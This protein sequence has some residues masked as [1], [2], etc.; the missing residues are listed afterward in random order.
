MQK[1]I[2]RIALA[3]ALVLGATSAQAKTLSIGTNPQGSLAYASG[4]AIADV[5]GDAMDASFTVV[6]QGGPTAIIPAMS[7]GEF[8]FAFANIVAAATALEGK[9]PFKGRKFDSI[10]VAAVV[11][12]LQLGVFVR[13]D[14][15]IESFDDLKGRRVASEFKSQSNL[16]GFMNTALA[17]A[18]MS[19]KDV[20][21][22]PV[23][24]GVQAVDELIDG[25]LDATIFS[26]SAGVVA[27][28]DA[29]T[30]IRM[31]SVPNTD[32]AKTILA[33]Q[34]PGATVATVA[35]G[36]TPGVD[37]EANVIQAPFV[38]L[39]D[40]SVDDETVYKLVKAIAEN[41]T[42]LVAAVEDFKDLDLKAMGQSDLPVPYHPGAIKY[43]KEQGVWK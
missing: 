8:E 1:F 36:S 6:P 13:D 16:A 18:G 5:A 29:V 12:P 30:G 38:V 33:Q 24:N 17:M 31:L 23:Q 42:K 37:A 34:R 15:G 32:K 26:T 20:K 39:A 40:S 43:F 4:S 2:S 11:Y 14:S 3:S 22:V 10:R 9:G 41:K 7:A 25:A 21:P 27:K 35:K 28:A 19:Y